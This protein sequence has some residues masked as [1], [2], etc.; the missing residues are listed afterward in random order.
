MK[1]TAR[2]HKSEILDDFFSVTDAKAYVKTE[3]NMLLAMRIDK[4]IKATGMNKV[5]FAEKI[6]VNPSVITKWLSGTHNFTTDTLFE[7]EEA[8]N[9]CLINTVVP[10]HIETIKTVFVQVASNNQPVHSGNYGLSFNSLLD[11]CNQSKCTY[12]KG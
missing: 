6:G 5:K 12:V 4:A 9:I 2:K 10:Q 7:I 1:K 8:L 11:I 3:K